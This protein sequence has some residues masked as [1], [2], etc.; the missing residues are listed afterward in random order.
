MNRAPLQLV[1]VLALLL[2]L[3][4]VAAAQTDDAYLER[5]D[6]AI[7]NLQ[8]SV[9]ALPSD[10]VQAREEL[11]SA[12]SVLLTMSREAAAG[13]LAAA[14]ERVVERARTAIG[15]ASQ[16]DLAVQVAVLEGG[17]Q[18]LV[19]DAALRA[20]ADGDLALARARLVRVG[21][22]L[23]MGQA[24]LATISDTTHAA[25]ALRFDFEAGVAD[26]IATRLAVAQE[27]ASSS[28]GGTYRALAR[29]YGAF[30]L[31]QDS[32]RA[33]PDLNQGF[34]TAAQALVDDRS[35]DAISAVATLRGQ[36][37]A[38]ASA[39]RSRQAAALTSPAI[40]VPLELP[41]T[42]SETTAPVIV[43]PTDASPDAA[44][45]SDVVAV[46]DAEAG[47]EADVTADPGTPVDLAA[48]DESELAGLLAELT[49]A[50]HAERVAVLESDLAALGVGI[51]TGTNLAEALLAAGFLRSEQAFDATAA[52]VSAAL[53][54]AQRGDAAAATAAMARAA[55]RYDAYVAPIVRSSLTLVD[56][57]TSTLLHLLAEDP[58]LRASDIAVAAGQ[59]D[60][61]ARALRGE[62]EAALLTGARTTLQLWSGLARPIVLMLIGLLALV[63]LV[64]SN[65]A[66]GGG[67]RNWQFVGIAVFIL[68]LP[69]LFEGLVG[70]GALLAELAGVEL[71]AL[72]PALSPFTSVVGQL[73]WASTALLAILFAIRGLYGI[74]T[75][76]GLLGRRP[77][78]AAAGAAAST[79]ATRSATST[80]SIDWDDD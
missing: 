1:R 45:T 51:A 8:R 44:A 57:E 19:F 34:V 75:Q 13:P 21:T 27:L 68:L 39:A 58:S 28:V 29:A 64:L 23:G 52:H 55:E 65:I 12:F 38:L 15:N 49:A 18:R 50:L 11:D 60:H 31:I 37:E 4:S 77:A 56:A 40:A 78:G 9:A 63:P 43:A 30:L 22:D 53:A 7:G 74:C 66:F 32:P 3:T 36:I 61:V 14:L 72:L 71:L 2:V 33:A 70:F 35:D 54:A 76:F 62:T 59:L 41:A 17:F 46:P 80:E 25:A 20:A 6:I 24:D 16:D 47:D 5:Y 79:R 10:A 73:V 42:P 69:V 26:V 48:L 67:N